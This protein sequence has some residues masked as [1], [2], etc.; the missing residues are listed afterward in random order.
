VI[1]V[2]EIRDLETAEIA[3]QAS[4]TGH[5]VFSTL[6]TNDAAGAITRL[7]DQGVEPFL[8]GSSLVATLAQRLIRLLCTRCREPYDPTAEELA[9]LGL[10]PSDL[11][12]RPIFRAVGCPACNGSG[13]RGQNAIFEVLVVN[14]EIRRLIARGIDSKTIQDAA[15]RGG[16]TTLRMDGTAKVLEGLTSIAEVLRQTDEEAVSSLE[17]MQA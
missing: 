17:P 14:D 8:I 7:I 15:V 3:I 12:G 11:L 10:S 16:M 5:L 9:Q 2:G 6:H 4:L 13:Y 1:L